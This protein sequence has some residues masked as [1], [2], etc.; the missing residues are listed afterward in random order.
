MSPTGE[1]YIMYVPLNSLE[2]EQ[3]CEPD[4]AGPP[5]A[6]GT[7]FPAAPGPPPPSGFG[8][9]PPSGYPPSGFGGPPSGPPPPPSGFGGPPP[10]A[11]PKPEWEQHMSGGKPYWHNN[12]T[13]ETTWDDPQKPKA[14]PS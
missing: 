6:P 12:R 7:G 3:I 1:E 9:P 11:P 14:P 10:P 8:P 2:G 13:G 5:T 4:S